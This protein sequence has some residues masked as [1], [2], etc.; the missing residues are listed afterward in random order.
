MTNAYQAVQWNN[1]KRLY[2]LCIVAFVAL[3]IVSF[4]A[5]GRVFFPPPGDISLTV[6]AIRATG[7]CAV[8]ML[9]VILIIGPLARISPLISP[10]LYNRRHLGVSFFIVASIHAS[11]VFGYYGGFGVQNPINAVLVSPDGLVSFELLGFLALLIFA[12]MAS[13]SHD[14]WLA[15]LGPSFWKTMHM[16]I[17]I[18]YALIIA[19]VVLGALRSEQSII[20]LTLVSIGATCVIGLH[21][22]SGWREVQ[23]DHRGQHLTEKCD[24]D[25]VS[26]IDVCSVDDIKPDRAHIA[27]IGTNE[28]IAVF[29]NGS[30]VSA[31]TN[32][33][34]HQGGPLGEGKIIDGCVTCPW[35]GYQFKPDCGQ[36]PPPYTEKIAT[37][38][39]RVEGRRVLINPTANEPGTPTQPASFV[40]WEE[41]KTHE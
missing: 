18:A 23:R 30:T 4:I 11:L 27:Q 10:L 33:C 17:Y 37:Y 36:S 41:D 25:A 3:F 14:F 31:I 15:N 20:P 1:H 32:V 38:D 6:L 39:I 13:T 16:G 35:H 5:L 40:P 8:L 26:W 19:H 28:R 7:F 24:E 2:D 22:Y 9:H 34:T 29:R 21:I 12:L